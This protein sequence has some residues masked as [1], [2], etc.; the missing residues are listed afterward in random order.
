MAT[1]PLNSTQEREIRSTSRCSDLRSTCHPVQDKPSVS[2]TIPGDDCRSE[3]TAGSPVKYANHSPT[4][5]PNCQKC[6]RKA[7][8]GALCSKCKHDEDADFQAEI[9]ASLGFDDIVETTNVDNNGHVRTREEANTVVT[10]G[11]GGGYEPLDSLDGEEAG[12]PIDHH[13]AR[14]EIG[15]KR[16]G[17]DHN[18]YSFLRNPGNNPAAK[19]FSQS[20][21]WYRPSSRTCADCRMH[22]LPCTHITQPVEPSK[23][24]R[25]HQTMTVVESRMTTQ[26]EEQSPPPKPDLSHDLGSAT[27]DSDVRNN[28]ARKTA[29][30]ARR[31][32][33]TTDTENESS[34]STPTKIRTEQL[35]PKSKRR[36][37]TS[38]PTSI[39][40]TTMDAARGSD[41]TKHNNWTHSTKP[42]TQQ[43][44]P[45]GKQ[46]M[47]AIPRN[48]A[49]ASMSTASSS[50]SNLSASFSEPPSDK[51][52]L[53]QSFGGSRFAPNGI[54]KPAT[55]ATIT[56]AATQP[57]RR[58]G[59]G[60]LPKKIN[61]PTTPLSSPPNASNDK[62]P[63][64]FP[65]ATPKPS[66][67]TSPTSNR[68]LHIRP[69][70]YW[71]DLI[72]LALSRAKDGKLTSI[73]IAE[74]IQ[75]EVPGYRNDPKVKSSISAVLSMYSK[76][77][78]LL[79]AKEDN[80]NR[81][82]I[83]TRFV[84]PKWLYR[85]RPLYRTY[86]S[87]E[88]IEQIF[89]ETRARDGRVP[90]NIPIPP[91]NRYAQPSF[92][93]SDELADNMPSHLSSDGDG[94]ANEL[95]ENDR[96]R[97]KGKVHDMRRDLVAP[98]YESSDSI[99]LSRRYFEVEAAKPSASHPTKKSPGRQRKLNDKSSRIVSAPVEPLAAKKQIFTRTRKR[100]ISLEASSASNSDSGS[101]VD[102]HGQPPPMKTNRH[103]PRNYVPSSSLAAL[104]TLP[105]HTEKNKAPVS[106]AQT[107]DLDFFI[108]ALNGVEMEI[109]N[110]HAP[111]DNKTRPGISSR[112]KDADTKQPGYFSEL[113][114]SP[115]PSRPHP[116]LGDPNFVAPN[117]LDE[118]PESREREMKQN[119]DELAYFK[120]WD[121]DPRYS[122]KDDFSCRHLFARRPDLHPDNVREGFDDKGKIEEIKSR[123]L[124]RGD[125]QRWKRRNG[126]ERMS[127][128]KTSRR[129]RDS[130][131]WWKDQGTK[132]GGWFDENDGD[133]EGGEDAGRGAN[134]GDRME[135][136][137]TEKYIESGEKRF[138]S[139]Q[140]LFELPDR[141][142][143]ELGLDKIGDLVFREKAGL[144]V[145]GRV[146]RGRK[147]FKTGH[148]DGLDL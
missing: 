95:D 130:K 1:E 118:F 74:W 57:P 26:P 91:T 39:G 2:V 123:K 81:L 138:K 72:Y 4:S 32:L 11:S 6:S 90:V 22:D 30:E 147:E 27:K 106:T 15:D 93:E 24:I 128:L 124:G 36:R 28:A 8:S 104:F 102:I 12:S 66:A 82:Q 140:K 86:L 146:K 29:P 52:G 88:Y 94:T 114:H 47:A 55:P 61:N 125:I 42:Q 109:E 83:G 68:V 17:S 51:N 16:R 59:Q 62:T 79:Y 103:R 99:P 85:L 119:A 43:E 112:K 98:E 35:P 100:H 63:A 110:L 92:T 111:D 10:K 9:L 41:D 145:S 142:Q 141:G 129:F 78:C 76:V 5:T 133:D 105:T 132:E 134:D 75:E 121:D 115:A 89:K 135:V 97:N 40:S 50:Q 69:N 96:I 84:G 56:E 70:L 34:D 19:K 21:S 144:N 45:A 48:G 77:K 33:S 87:I 139:L 122:K 80:P 23:L 136:D 25:A 127:D 46:Q 117:I 54:S 7:F 148:P 64:S 44:Q 116:S 137:D 3:L 65:A 143:L 31:A 13:N 73:A 107:T 60:N 71:N 67:P 37:E 126:G 58:H 49:A 18:P 131:T 101:E 120:H 14:N 53:G 38:Q 20:S 108:A 113:E